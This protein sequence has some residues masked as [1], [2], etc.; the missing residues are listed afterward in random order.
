MKKQLLS[1]VNRVRE[2]MGLKVLLEQKEVIRTL[3]DKDVFAGNTLVPIKFPDNI[4]LPIAPDNTSI[5]D[6]TQITISN[7]LPSLKEFII[8]LKKNLAVD[9]TPAKMS[10][11]SG[12][13]PTP[14][15]TAVP[16]GYS[17]EQVDFSYGGEEP[18][19]QILADKRGTVIL[20]LLNRIIPKQW[21][22]KYKNLDHDKIVKNWN[23][24]K[25]L[26]KLNAKTKSTKFVS[27]NV[28][29]SKKIKGTA[30][31]GCGAKLD[32]DGGQ[33]DINNNWIAVLK[34]IKDAEVQ[35][36]AEGYLN[37]GKNTEGKITLVFDPKTVP[38]AFKVT[39]NEE[40]T[41]VPFTTNSPEAMDDE[42]V[43][44]PFTNKKGETKN[45]VVKFDIVKTLIEAYDVA[46]KERS[47]ILKA[48]EK[49]T[50]Q[51]TR[52]FL[53]GIRAKYGKKTDKPLT[54][55][56]LCLL[57]KRDSARFK[58]Y[59]GW[60]EGISDYVYKELEKLGFD[61]G[62]QCGELNQWSTVRNEAHTKLRDN[63]WFKIAKKR[64]LV[65]YDNDTVTWTL[66]EEK[67]KELGG[68]SYN[69]RLRRAAE[70]VSDPKIKELLIQGVV[71]KPQGVTIDKIYGIPKVRIEVIA[72][73]GGTYFTI[74]LK[75]NTE[76]EKP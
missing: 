71:G 50:T 42:F 60:S 20:E 19:N 49:S 56:H 68:G 15:N 44:V 17:Q 70:D 7:M 32:V 27:I 8:K 67:I 75:C 38:D 65:T 66:D 61:V 64:Q 63:K 22:G 4:V 73:L 13:S 52:T 1:E 58:K 12:A 18:D 23:D 34:P 57:Q 37:L 10:I 33:G 16:K 11:D 43:K 25:A 24:L 72:P 3:P 31:Y 2:I 21:G 36:D 30:I 74:G 46:N 5:T 6:V 53:Q 26:I 9:Y 39:Y 47:K 41:Y 55:W 69:Q 29:G 28:E 76:K 48:I 35:L 54:G 40:V 51:E 62:N 14:A 59:F 45:A